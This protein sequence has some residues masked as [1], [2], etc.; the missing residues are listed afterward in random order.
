MKLLFI[1]DLCFSSGA[2]LFLSEFDAVHKTSVSLDSWMNRN[3]WQFLAGA[4]S[5][6]GT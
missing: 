2:N 3:N 4:S 5:P 6:A 1:L